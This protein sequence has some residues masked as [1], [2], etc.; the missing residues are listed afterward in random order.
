MEKRSLAVDEQLSE[1]SPKKLKKSTE[2]DQAVEGTRDNVSDSSCISGDPTSDSR[3]DEVSS[4]GLIETDVGITEYISKHQGFRGILKERYSDFLVN[5][6][7]KEGHLVRVSDLTKPKNI[8]KTE[9]EI[10]AVEEYIK[11]EDQK[12]LQELMEDDDK[13]GSVLINLEDDDKEAR[14]KVHQSIRQF[15]PGLESQTLE[16]NGQKV[17]EVVK[18]KNKGRN[19]KDRSRW[20]KSCPNHC[21]FVLY[22]E[23]IETMNAI[24]LLARLLRIPHHLFSFAGTKDKRA[25]TVQEVTAYRVEAPRLYGLNKT[26]KNI[27]LS[28]FRYCK[29]ALRLGDLSGN[30]FTIVIRSVEANDSEIESAMTSFQNTGFINYYGMQRF[31][32]TAIANF[33]VGRAILLSDW[34]EAIELIL[35]PRQGESSEMQSAREHWWQTRD[36]QS[37]SNLMKNAKA[38]S[39]E[40]MLLKALCK[41]GGSDN[42]VKA[43]YAIPKQTRLMYVHSY[44]SYVWNRMASRR[45]T[46]YGLKPIIGD[47]LQCKDSKKSADIVEVTEDNIDK[48]SIYDVVLP[49]PGYDSIYPKNQVGV[50]YK[51]ILSEDGLDINNMK[52]SVKDYSLVGSYRKIVGKPEQCTWNIY[53]YNDETIPLTLSDLD[54]L[55]DK[56]PPV[57]I[58]D[59]KLKALKL[60]FTLPTSCYAT[61]AIREIMKQDTSKSHQCSLMK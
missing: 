44:Q 61:M 12:K 5:E 48:C 11:E 27:K 53:V 15:F 42:L 32:T 21:C 40:Y 7:S 14:T 50:W 57:S 33:R 49:M 24:N 55:E 18:A 43:L 37:S 26:L 23:N 19:R 47:L 30:H 35:K 41:H 22:K 13:A 29:D 2:D 56:P 20:P 54:L 34:Q 28:N 51:E 4:V 39:I 6:R 60:E 38:Y 10:D 31:G 8:F 1:S 46:E 59:G 36:A 25:I 17:I 9:N 58:P 45:I 3:P 16:K 52:H